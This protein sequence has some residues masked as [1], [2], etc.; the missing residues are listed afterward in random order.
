MRTH[1]SVCVCVLVYLEALLAKHTA[2]ASAAEMLRVIDLLV[3]VNHTVF[4]G[5]RALAASRRNEVCVTGVTIGILLMFHERT[6]TF[7]C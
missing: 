1:A 4:D 2:T 6:C 3:P 7:T 5:K